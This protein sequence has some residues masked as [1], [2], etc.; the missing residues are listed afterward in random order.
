V[1]RCRACGFPSPL[2]AT[3]GMRLCWTCRRP[4]ERAAE[5]GGSGGWTLEAADAFVVR[6]VEVFGGG[7]LIE[8]VSTRLTDP[9]PAVAFDR[10]RWLA[11][12]PEIEDMIRCRGAVKKTGERCTNRRRPG[13]RC[14]G[15]HRSC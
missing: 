11:E 15:I 8:N 3:T 6:A 7:E 12:H 13:S 1:N 9:L 14:C 10:A 4:S 5:P 2:A